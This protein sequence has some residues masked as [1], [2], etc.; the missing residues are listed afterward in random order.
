MGVEHGSV[1]AMR[2]DVH[3]DDLTGLGAPQD[4]SGHVAVVLADGVRKS[5]ARR[6]A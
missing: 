2:S 6:M 4:A 1:A 3:E 5:S